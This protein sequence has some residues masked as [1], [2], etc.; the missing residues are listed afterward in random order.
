MNYLYKSA[1]FLRQEISVNDILTVLCVPAGQRVTEFYRGFSRYLQADVGTS[2]Q[3][4]PA[5]FPFTFFLIRYCL[6]SMSLDSV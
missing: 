4:R 1:F 6:Y 2:L 5:T 3:T